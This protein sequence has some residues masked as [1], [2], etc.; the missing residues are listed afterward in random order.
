MRI[1][2][3]TAQAVTLAKAIKP[4]IGTDPIRHHL[5]TVELSATRETATFTATDGYRMHQV[6]VNPAEGLTYEAGDS[7][8]V[9]GKELLDTLALFAKINGK[10]EGT[11]TITD[12]VTIH[13]PCGAVKVSASSGDISFVDL[14]NRDF[15]NCAS[16][17]N[18]APVVSE[19][20]CQYEAEFLADIVTAA[21]IV[22]KTRKRKG[23]ESMSPVKI[24]NIH[25]S[26]PCHVTATNTDLGMEFHGVIMP[27]RP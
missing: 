8:N 20:V 23:I 3:S 7:I 10:G 24:M 9:S 21:G 5:M 22:G 25:P 17:L 15:P 12:D 18:T 26:K 19:S 16:I 13:D 2:L 4:A 6:T 14:V 27:Q 1:T 11:V